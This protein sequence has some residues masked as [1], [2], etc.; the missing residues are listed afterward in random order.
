MKVDL[1]DTSAS[2]VAAALVKARIAAGSP[3]MGMVLTLIVVTDEARYYDAMRASRVISREH[4]ARVL[5]VILREKR[6]PASLDAQVRIGNDSA[7][8]SVILRMSGELTQ[9]AE[10]VVLP[11][12]LPDSPVVAW[13]PGSAPKAPA[14]DPLGSLATRR[15]TDA[16]ASSR[17]RHAA[18]IRVAR[19]YQPG[20]TDL[21]WTRLTP[22]R[23]LLAAALDQVELKV[24]AGTVIAERGNPSADLL[25]AWLESRL[26]VPVEQHVSRGPGITEV[27]LHSTIGD[28][29]VVR[30]DGRNGRFV[31]PGEADRTVA[32]RRRPTAELL[33]EDLRRLDEDDIYRDTIDHLLKRESRGGRTAKKP[34][35]KQ[36]AKAAKA[37][38]AKTTKTGTAKT[39]TAKTGAPKAGAP[40]AGKPSAKAGAKSERTR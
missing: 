11:L 2:A 30:H 24:T 38:P 10:G 34:A 39:G 26:K 18:M 7:G 20:D 17:T 19:A 32:L 37:T 6:G 25:A 22:W 40:K 15:I 31:V 1:N 27:R 28:V 16:A 13:W 35:P 9:H 21:A 8:E 23:A 3:A 36:A 4:P 12:L 14:Q 5:G 29:A 33:A